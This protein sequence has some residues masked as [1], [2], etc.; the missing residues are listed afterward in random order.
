MIQEQILGEVTKKV[1]QN[2]A[3]N[4]LAGA[5]VVSGTVDL[6]TKEKVNVFVTEVALIASN[7]SFLW[8]PRVEHGTVVRAK[9]QGK[10][11]IM[12]GST[13]YKTLLDAYSLFSLNANGTTS[14][15]ENMFVTPS[16][17]VIINADDQL[18]N[19]KQMV[20]GI[21][22]AP[23]HAYREDKIEEFDE[24]VVT[25]TTAGSDSGDL[26]TADN[27]IERNYNMGA[28]IWNKAALPTTVAGFVKKQ[29]MA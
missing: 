27:V 3:T 22:G 10:A 6:S 4:I 9:Y 25:R 7:N 2:F 5:T 8:K 29:L 18:G 15:V 13:A 20:Y 24:R 26:V 19:A 17:V 11:F 1:N 21:A 23:V 16:G 28:G 12:A 14:G